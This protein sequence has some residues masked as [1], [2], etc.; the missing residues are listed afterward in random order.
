[1]EIFQILLVILSVWVF[2]GGI[3]FL[4]TSRLS[5]HE[6]KFGL[7]G[8]S[9]L[10]MSITFFVMSGLII[11]YAVDPDNP[12]TKTICNGYIIVYAIVTI[13][14]GITEKIRQNS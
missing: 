7:T 4:R 13:I 10:L 1:M 2:V 5:A 3:S 8:I 14:C 11:W 9:A 6:A 12:T